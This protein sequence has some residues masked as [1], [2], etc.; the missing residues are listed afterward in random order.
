MDPAEIRARNFIRPDEFP[1]PPQRDLCTTVATTCRTGAGAGE[2]G[3]AD[4]R[5][6]QACSR[7]QGRKWA[8]AWRLMS[9]LRARTSVCPRCGWEAARPAGTVRQGHGA[10][11]TSPH[12]QGGETTFAQMVADGLGCARRTMSPCSTATRRRCLRHRYVWQPCSRGRRTA[13]MMSVDKIKAKAKKFAGQCWK[14]CL[15]DMIYDARARS[16]SHGHPD[17]G[18]DPGDSGRR[19]VERGELAAR[20]GAGPNE[21]SYFEPSMHLPLSAHPSAWSR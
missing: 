13:L 5:R 16:T 19:I 20:H 21:T 6:E 10:T 9:N 18:S 1:Y 12:G 2:A 11:G 7:T 15:T 3:Y 8:S 14:L 17:K 4:L